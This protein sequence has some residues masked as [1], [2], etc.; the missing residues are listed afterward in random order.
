LNIDVRFQDLRL[1]EVKF[2]LVIKLFNFGVG[3]ADE[4]LCVEL[5]NMWRDSVSEQELTVQIFI[6]IYL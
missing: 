1:S 3:K 5:T 2:A 6:H 4:D